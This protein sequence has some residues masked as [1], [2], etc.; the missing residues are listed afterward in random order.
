M[1]Y[2][3]EKIIN[4]QPPLSTSFITVTRHDYP[5]LTLL[6]SG[7]ISLQH[8]PR[9]LVKKPNTTLGSLITHFKHF[10]DVPGTIPFLTVQLHCLWRLYNSVDALQLKEQDNRSGEISSTV[11]CSG[12]LL[13]YKHCGKF[14]SLPNRGTFLLATAH[15]YESSAEGG[16]KDKIKGSLYRKF[17][18]V[19]NSFT[20][21]V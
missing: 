11:F 5:G 14:L 8:M 7:H 21:T 18:K 6:A 16:K 15:V 19:T 12:D 4:A 2:H 10:R 3:K 20:G 13:S 1:I 17:W 9:L